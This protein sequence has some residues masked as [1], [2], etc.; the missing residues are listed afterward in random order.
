MNGDECTKT[1]EITVEAA[2]FTID[3]TTLP[4]GDILRRLTRIW[5]HPRGGGPSVRM[6]ARPLRTFS[7]IHSIH[8]RCCLRIQSRQSGEE[9]VGT[10]D[11]S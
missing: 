9:K 1:A 5:R 6:R 11:K 10:V 7:H 2:Y 3:A 4:R 8:T